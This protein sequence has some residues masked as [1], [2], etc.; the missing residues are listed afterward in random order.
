MQV[1]AET[2]R[3]ETMARFEA[4]AKTAVEEIH[5]PPRTRQPSCVDRPTTTSPPSATGRRPRSPGSARRPRAGSPPA[6]PTRRRDRG[7]RRPDRSAIERVTGAVAAFE[8][9]MEEFFERLSAEEDPTRSPPWPRPARAAEPAMSGW[10]TSSR[11]CRAAQQSPTRTTAPGPA[12]ASPPGRS[13]G[14]AGRRQP[15]HDPGRPRSSGRRRSRRGRRRR[16]AQAETAPGTLRPYARLRGRR[17][18]GRRVQPPKRR[19]AARGDPD[20]SPTILAARLAGCVPDKQLRPLDRRRPTHVV[21]P[22][23]VSVASIASFKRQPRPH[24]RRHRSASPP[25]PTASSS[26]PSHHDADVDL[27]AAIT[28]LPGLRGPRQRPDRRRHRGRRARPRSRTDSAQPIQSGVIP[29][30]S[31]SRRRPPGR[32][33]GP[34]VS[35]L[36][37]AGFEVIESTQPDRPRARAR[38]RT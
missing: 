29:C 3:N 11:G 38:R 35:E 7:P 31:S 14:A 2:A 30:P 10:T 21:V 6:R 9:E 26:S 1:A 34:V 4:E 18:R 15:R 37:D 36:P 13:A 20:R 19:R 27:A 17:G 16:R 33:I 8:A 28:A 12:D 23:L 25:A 5:A 22:G 32:R 24:P